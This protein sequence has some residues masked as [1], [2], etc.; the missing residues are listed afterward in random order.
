MERSRPTIVTV[1]AVLQFIPAFLLPPS[2][3]LSAP[4]FLLLV[5]V[6]LFVFMGWAMLTL[7]PWAT[8]L[9][10][11]VQGF[12][13]IARF[14]IMFPQASPGEN[15]NLVFVLTSLA[16]IGLSTA[17]LYVI[18]RPNVQVAFQA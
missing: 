13:V 6:A 5:P 8:T 4:T 9:C 12:N 17:I 2:I 15:T 18:D 10:M 16:S 11:F 14:L 3:L 7:K 1:V